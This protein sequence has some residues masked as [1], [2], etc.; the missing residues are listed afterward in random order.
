[1]ESSELDQ[2]D[3]CIRLELDKKVKIAVLPQSLLQSGSKQGKLLNSVSLAN[4]G[5]LI[6][7]AAQL[8]NGIHVSQS[9]YQDSPKSFEWANMLQ[10]DS[11]LVIPASKRRAS[12]TRM[13]IRGESSGIWEA[14]KLLSNPKRTDLKIG[15]YKTWKE[16]SRVP[17]RLTGAKF[18]R[19]CREEGTIYRAP[20]E[21]SR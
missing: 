8:S 9:R 4:C 16:S 17:S 6:L 12:I 13:V 20:T 15:H 2:P 5:N 3:F 21:R 19:S 18:N 10:P 11:L 14:R 1:M 7:Y